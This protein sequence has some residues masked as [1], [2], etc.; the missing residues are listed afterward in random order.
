MYSIYRLFMDGGSE[1]IEQGLTL[2]EAQAH[3]RDP[4]TSSDTCDEETDAL[5]QGRGKWF[6]GYESEE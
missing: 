1:I 3:C 4:N 6:D 5:M 2:D